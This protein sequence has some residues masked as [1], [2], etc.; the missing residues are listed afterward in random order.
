[1]TYLARI[2][3]MLYP[4]FTDKLDVPPGN[5]AFGKCISKVGFIGISAV[6]TRIIESADPGIQAT[7]HKGNHLIPGKTFTTA[8]PAHRPDN[9][10][11]EF[12]C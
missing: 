4:A 5:A 3:N 12:A 7:V 2:G 10:P 9:N 1:M 8:A 6:D 11:R